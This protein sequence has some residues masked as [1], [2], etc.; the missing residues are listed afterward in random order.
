MK[1]YKEIADSVLSRRD[2]YRQTQKTLRIASVV[3]VFVVMTVLG[4]GIIQGGTA[5]QGTLPEAVGSNNQA[6]L[7]SEI[8]GGPQNELGIE[9]NGGYS[10]ENATNQTGRQETITV[11]TSTHEQTP[12]EGG[13][14]LVFVTTQTSAPY[15]GTTPTIDGSDDLTGGEFS[16]WFNIPALPFEKGFELTGEELTD[17]EA[18]A[19]FEENIAE[20]T[21]TLATSG[22]AADAIDIAD[23]GYCHVNYNGTE[24]KLLEIR[25][26]FRD[27]LVYNNGELISIITLY[28]ENGEIYCTPAF[29]APWF[30]DFN[31]YLQQHSGEELIFI[32]AGFM[33]MVIAP[34]N[35]FRN[36]MGY[37]IA[38]YFEGI[39]K[40]YEV[41]Y[42][43]SAVYVP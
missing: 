22:V 42:H 38:P 16:N 3:S 21:D 27:Y 4:I 25:Q 19:Y 31:A 15:Q 1:H 33:E 6:E 5:A 30:A 13:N 43:E 29:G 14:E 18:Q 34:D 24:G 10:S 11:Q 9:P 36:P 35:S 39:E 7:H 17:D 12:P 20:I 37:E 32:Y 26:N 40:P 2:K 28:K 23:K 8:Y 41:F